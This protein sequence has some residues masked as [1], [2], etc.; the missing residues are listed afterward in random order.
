[1]HNRFVDV[2]V[3]GAGVAGL[4]AARQLESEGFEVLILEARNR[5]G[6]RILTTHDGLAEGPVE[7]G[8]EF[9]RGR[10]PELVRMLEGAGLRT[11]PVEG[12]D[13]CRDAGDIA[14][15]GGVLEQVDVC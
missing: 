10:P 5:I 14:P 3:I 9:V 11:E 15:D 2:I 12:G 4:T 13:I 8:A 7:L 1:M 6:G